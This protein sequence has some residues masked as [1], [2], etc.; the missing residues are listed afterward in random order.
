MPRHKIGLTAVTMQNMCDLI[1]A[2]RDP[3]STPVEFETVGDDLN[4]VPIEAGFGTAAWEWDVLSQEDYDFILELQ[5][6][7]PGRAMYIYTTKRNGAS[8]IDFDTYACIAKRPTFERRE[9]FLC[10]GVRIEFVQLV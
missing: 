9:E 7:V 10:Y 5:G 8:G 3:V 6:D 2:G 1:K 4:G